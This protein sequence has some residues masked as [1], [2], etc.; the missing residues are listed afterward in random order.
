MSFFQPVLL[1]ELLKINLKNREW[2][3]IFPLQEMRVVKFNWRHS[4]VARNVIYIVWAKRYYFALANSVS[5]ENVKMKELY[6]L[7]EAYTFAN[8]MW[9]II[10][11]Q[12]NLFLFY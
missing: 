3:K 6:A 10:D 9:Y 11:R 7:A 2:T 8:K 4:D 1:K 12:G 5:M